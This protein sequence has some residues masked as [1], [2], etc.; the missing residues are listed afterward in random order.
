[1]ARPKGTARAIFARRPY[2]ETRPIQ[3][4]KRLP[5]EYLERQAKRHN[6]R[7]QERPAVG[8]K[9]SNPIY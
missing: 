9:A 2:Y 4:N 6:S 8:A 7:L 3:Q 1:M 5:N